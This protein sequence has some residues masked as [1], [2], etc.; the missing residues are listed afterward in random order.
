[1]NKLF[2][3]ASLL[4]TSLFS[5]GQKADE[6]T[7]IVFS[8]STRGYLKQVLFDPSH[9]EVKEEGSRSGENIN[10]SR[11]LNKKEWAQLCHEFK[12]ISL[13]EIPDLQS[14][15]M[16]RAS[17]AAMA[18]TITITTKKGKTVTHDFDNENPHEKLQGLMKAILNITNQG[19]GR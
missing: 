16:K 10:Y 9:L 1:M 7:Q 3:V 6:I 8:T 4:L 13:G 2:V 15:S 14:P 18:S 19:K 12:G 5:Y 17:D 11:R